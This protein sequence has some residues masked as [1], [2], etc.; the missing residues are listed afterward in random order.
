MSA[1]SNMVRV[2]VIGCGV[3]AYWSH[4][5]SLRRLPGARLVAAA[6]PDAEARERAAKLA[7][8]ETHA[9]AAE[10]LA[11][12]D[13][14]AVVLSAPTPLHAELG[15]AAAQ[16][17]KAIYLEKPAASTAA[18]AERLRDAVERS[19]VTVAVG[20]NRRF[21]PLCLQARELIRSGLLGAVRAVLSTFNEPLTEADTPPWKRLRSSGGGA[22]LDLGSHHFDLLPWLLDDP[23]ASVEAGVSSRAT[24]DDEAWARSMTTSGVPVQSCFSFRAAR[25]DFAEI[26]GERGVLRVDR[27]R[28]ALTLETS[29]RFGYGVRR[30]DLPAPLGLR[31][32]RLA[33]PSYDPSYRAA[34]AGFVERLR[35]GKG[36]IATLGDGLLSLSVVLAAEQASREGRSVN[37]GAPACAS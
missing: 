15:V 1:A 20:F 32:R 30:A 25:A 11:R 10:L 5:R 6:D 23:I 29:R 12:T 19:G 27:H 31:L 4:L 14:D 24:E 13:I 16:A 35:G 26:V 37:V 3:I 2:G 34:L 33:S 22:L 18:E 7:G 17:G 28:A 36:E 21:H 8:C 9:D